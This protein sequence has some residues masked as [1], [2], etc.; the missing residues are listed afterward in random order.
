[1]FDEAQDVSWRAGNILRLALN[2]GDPERVEQAISL[3]KEAVAL[4]PEC[5]KAYIT[6][7]LSYAMQSLF[8]WG[9]D[10]NGAADWSEH[11]AKQFLAKAPHSYWAHFCLGSARLRKGQLSEAIGDLRHAHELNPNEMTILQ[12]LSYAE[13]RAGE[14]IAA[15][16][17]AQQAIRLSPKD[18]NIGNAYLA[19]SLA[20]FVEQDHDEFRQWAEKAIRAAPNAPIRRALMIAHAAIIGDQQLLE[21]HRDE[22]MR[23]APDFIASI[24]SG[25]NKQFERP[26]HMELLLNGLRKAGFGED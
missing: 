10:P 14:T 17:L 15:R 3:S 7:C 6:I 24:F 26:E 25:E 19:L 21:T 12:T 20:A 13:A 1:V 8:R 16:E 23:F 2:A 18:P 4:N 11:W 22:L 5:F 9:E